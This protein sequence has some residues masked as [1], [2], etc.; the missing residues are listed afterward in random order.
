MG[1]ISEPVF[2]VPL[3]NWTN[4]IPTLLNHF[5]L[6]T[7]CFDHKGKKKRTTINNGFQHWNVPSKRLFPWIRRF[8][9]IQKDARSRIGRLEGN[10]PILKWLESISAN[11]PMSWTP[12]SPQFSLKILVFLV[13]LETFSCGSFHLDTM[14][15]YYR[16]LTTY[17][18]II[19]R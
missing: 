5:P 7:Q 16:L 2:P 19:N 18:L 12:P 10:H 15:T 13:V 1:R 3:D 17:L 14:S 8:Q 4:L 9:R 6:Q 11:V